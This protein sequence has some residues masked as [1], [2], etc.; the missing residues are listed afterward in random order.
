[1]GWGLPLFPGRCYFSSWWMEEQP[2]GFLLGTFGLSGV[3][4]Y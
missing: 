1:M 4:V 3:D 2:P